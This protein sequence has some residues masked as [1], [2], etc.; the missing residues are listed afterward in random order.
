RCPACITA[1]KVPTCMPLIIQ[2]SYSRPDSV[3]RRSILGARS[4]NLGSIRLEYMSGGS[5]MWESADISLYSAIKKPPLCSAERVRPIAPKCT[6][7]SGFWNRR[8]EAKASQATG[9]SAYDGTRD[10]V[11]STAAGA[12]APPDNTEEKQEDASF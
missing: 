4:R 11:S 12:K 10:Q 5:T 8:A 2:A 7:A 1:P 3:L 6:L 9:R